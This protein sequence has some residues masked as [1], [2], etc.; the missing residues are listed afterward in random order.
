MLHDAAVKKKIEFLVCIPSF[1]GY[2]FVL[3]L[4]SGG[5]QLAGTSSVWRASAITELATE[6]WG[7]LVKLV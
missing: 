5:N 6:E 1:S 7:Q 4:G 3:Q 2:L